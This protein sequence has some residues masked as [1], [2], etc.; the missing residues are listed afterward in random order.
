MRKKELIQIHKTLSLALKEIEE[1]GES[2]P[3]I[4][5]D[6]YKEL[7][8]NPTDIHKKKSSQEDAILELAKSI[9]EGIEDFREELDED[10]KE[11]ARDIDKTSQDIIEAY[12][13]AQG[14]EDQ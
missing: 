1:D 8:V 6:Q 7:G 10:E 12:N 3:D 11:I 2:S 9:G 13:N 5:L 14:L 4:N